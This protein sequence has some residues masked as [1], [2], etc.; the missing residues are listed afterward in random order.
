MNLTSILDEFGT[1]EGLDVAVG[2]LGQ[3]GIGKHVT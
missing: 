2:E 1:V 3:I